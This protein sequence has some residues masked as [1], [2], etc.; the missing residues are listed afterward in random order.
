MCVS[1][2][3]TFRFWVLAYLDAEKRQ[4]M[5]GRQLCNLLF[6]LSSDQNPGYVLYMGVSKNRVPPNHQF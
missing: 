6:H 3:C 2:A 5:Q 4:V 1:G